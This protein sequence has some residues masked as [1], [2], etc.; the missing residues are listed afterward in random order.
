MDEDGAN[1]LKNPEAAA[2]EAQKEDEREQRRLAREEQK[3]TGK[4][5]KPGA[6]GSVSKTTPIDI[7]DESTVDTGILGQEEKRRGGSKSQDKGKTKPRAKSVPTEQAKKVGTR[8]LSVDSHKHRRRRNLKRERAAVTLLQ[9]LQNAR[10]RGIKPVAPRVSSPRQPSL[11]TVC[12][13]MKARRRQR[14]RVHGQREEKVMLRRL[15]R[16]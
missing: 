2:T 1:N 3:R 15:Q 13:T 9:A 12:M 16:R 11:T 10:N 14:K 7:D 8:S 6:K 5:V 4:K